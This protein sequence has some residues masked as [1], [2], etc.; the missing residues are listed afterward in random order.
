MTAN[1]GTNCATL[2]P[3]AA[4]SGMVYQ[5]RLLLYCDI[6][7]WSAEIASGDSSKLLASVESI[8]RRA[9]TYNEREREALRAQDVKIIQTD[10][11]S[12][13]HKKMMSGI[14]KKLLASDVV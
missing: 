14:G 13:F 10:I 7:G 12:F 8:H 6:L 3:G 2:K 1:S 11:L 4:R 9:D 5:E